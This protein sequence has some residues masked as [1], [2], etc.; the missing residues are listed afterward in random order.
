ML[1]VALSHVLHQKKFFD[2]PVLHMANLVSLY[3][4]LIYLPV[5]VTVQNSPHYIHVLL[6]VIIHGHTMPSW[7]QMCTL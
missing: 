4:R 1:L 3:R 2:V 6:N 7:H 5:D